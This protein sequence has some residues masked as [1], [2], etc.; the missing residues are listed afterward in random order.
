[1]IFKENSDVMHH[2]NAFFELNGEFDLIFDKD[3]N[4][5]WMDRNVTGLNLVGWY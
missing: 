4:V 3:I 5:S 2:S 1:M